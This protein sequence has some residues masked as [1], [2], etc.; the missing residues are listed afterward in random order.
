MKVIKKIFGIAPKQDAN[1]GFTPSPIALK[2][3]T[4]NKT[5]Y[6]HTVYPKVRQGNDRKILMICTEERYMNMQNGTKFSTGNHPVEML[7][8]M[9]HL[10]KA[11]FE[12]DI[13]TPTG[14][15]VAIEMWA[16]PN[17]D[18]AVKGMYQKYQEK[19][20]TPMSLNQLF[21]STLID[22]DYVAVFIPGGHGAMLGLPENSDLERLI[23]WV[24]DKDKYMLAICHGPAALLAAG[25]NS[26]K[27]SFLYRGYKMAVFPDALDK[28]TPMFGYIPGHMPW[29]FGEKLR[30]L[31]VEIINKK[32]NGTCYQDRKLITGDSP[33]AA[34]EFGKMAA[35][36]LITE[37]S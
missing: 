31:G 29:Y 9:L 2:L 27:S 19:F 26:D 7:V 4:K 33:S 28:Q 21:D 10:E 18:D 23:Q 15:S 32:A 6:D 34:N 36:A 20:E 37:L 11:G 12:F 25:L 30:E 3:A 22:S 24:H 13:C 35:K 8:P 1:G 5:D 17:K 14:K 16:M